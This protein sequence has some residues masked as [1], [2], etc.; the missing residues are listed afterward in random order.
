MLFYYN[1]FKNSYKL[2]SRPQIQHKY[3]SK[4]A[5]PKPIKNSETIKV[6]KKNS[7]QTI[8]TKNELSKIIGFE[9]IK[10][11]IESHNHS[12]YSMF[13]KLHPNY[14]NEIF[15]PTGDNILHIAANAGDLKILSEELKNK[16]DYRLENLNKNN[17]TPLITAIKALNNCEDFTYDT[18]IETIEYM[19]NMGARTSYRLEN[20]EKISAASELLRNG[21]KQLY[22]KLLFI[23]IKN[24][25]LSKKDLNFIAEILEDTS[26]LVRSAKAINPYDD[27]SYTPLKELIKF[28]IDIGASSSHT[29]NDVQSKKELATTELLKNGEIELYKYAIL[30]GA[31]FE[32]D[33]DIDRNSLFR[34]Y[35]IN[36]LA[37]IKFLQ[38]ISNSSLLDATIN[39]PEIANFD[40]EQHLAFIS[41]YC[42]TNIRIN[43]F[44]ARSNLEEALKKEVISREKYEFVTNI[45]NIEVSNGLS[46]SDMNEVYDYFTG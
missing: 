44:E 4:Q 26:I 8:E 2:I 46:G 25:G 9:H 24:K 27:F 1:L 29:H 45:L 22:K 18:R 6:S 15:T 33:V 23:N 41:E 3:Y 31:E 7:K 12:L 39:L 28:L 11:T 20:G 30:N 34:D 36:M 17:E 32:T 35:S 21:E 42:D 13:K 16:K 38:A 10:Y 43:H 14:K 37:I 19:V 40:I 5:N